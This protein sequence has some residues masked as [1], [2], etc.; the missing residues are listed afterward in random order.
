MEKYRKKKNEQADAREFIK[1]AI[2]YLKKTDISPEEI[3]QYT[4]IKSEKILCY[5]EEKERPTLNHAKKLVKYFGMMQEV[6]S[7]ENEFKI[8]C[9]K[10]E[11]KEAFNKLHLILNSKKIKDQFKCNSADKAIKILN[12]GKIEMNGYDKAH[13]NSIFDL[14]RYEQRIPSELQNIINKISEIF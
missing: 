12:K 8:H 7:S 11:Y 2:D 6:I 4:G 14:I 1:K 10:R 13:I 3:H 5:K 9:D